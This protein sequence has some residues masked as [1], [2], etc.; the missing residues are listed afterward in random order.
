MN[1]RDPIRRVRVI[2]TGTV[3]IHPEHMART[4]QPTFLSVL[5]SRR[6]TA[7]LPINVYVIEHRNGLVLF[8]TGQ[9]RSSVTD[10]RYFPSGLLLG[11][12]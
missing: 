9:D 3:Q 7:P 1:D 11:P 5:T 10:P 4:W 12:L 8:D 2:S 6:W